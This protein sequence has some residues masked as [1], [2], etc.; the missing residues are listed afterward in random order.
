MKSTKIHTIDAVRDADALVDILATG[1][2]FPIVVTGSSMIPFL[3]E[4]R[5]TV[6]LQKTDELC[7]GRIVF[8]RR[9]SGEFVLHR[10]RK[11]Y[12]DGRILVNGDAQS[13]C[14]I[15]R[16]DNVLAEV[17]SIKRNSRTIDPRGITS[18]LLS[19]LWYPTLPIRPFILRTYTSLKRLFTNR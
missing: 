18:S 9:N 8:F 12:P 5:D 17:I 15:T 16:R 6:I 13:W 7:K 19:A 11:I 4:G 2:P 14:E 1:A 10:I 3:K